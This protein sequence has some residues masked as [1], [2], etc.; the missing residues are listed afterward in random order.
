VP[1]VP[2]TIA[3]PI[4]AIPLRYPLGRLG[5]LSALV[6]GSVT[7]DIPLYLPL[8][9]HRNVTHSLIGLLWF[10]LPVGA[11]A[12]LLFD[13]VLERPLRALMPEAI[14]RRLPP[15]AG[16]KRPPVWSLAALLSIL[17]GAATHAVWDSFTHGGAAGVRLFPVLETRLFTL[18]GYTAYVFSVLQH[19]SSIVGTV[20]MAVWL[21]RWYRTAPRT[22]LADAS[23]LTPRARRWLLLA[24]GLVVLAAAAGG[25]VSRFPEEPTLRA[26]QPFARRIIVAGLSSLTAALMLYGVAWHWMHARGAPET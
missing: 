18:S 16:P 6:I 8:S 25:G 9:L 21:R 7:P 14:Q 22:A 4:A 24:I 3:H 23:D 10:C 15:A 26:L 19:T 13:R 11:L 1:D 17:A 2:V 5:V 20:V 12:Y